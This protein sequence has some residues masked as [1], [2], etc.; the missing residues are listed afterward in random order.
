MTIKINVSFT[1]LLLTISSCNNILVKDRS[2]SSLES[3][4]PEI[5]FV[6]ASG[7]NGEVGIAML[8]NPTVFND[9]GLPVSDCVSSPVLPSGLSISS[10]TCSISGT[11]TSTLSTTTYTVTATN[12][13]GSSSTTVD[14]T[15]ASEPPVISYSSTSGNM[16]ALLSVTPALTSAG[17]SI[18]SCTSSP[19]L[20]NGLSIDNSTCVISGAPLTRLD[21]TSYTITAI[22]SGGGSTDTTFNLEVGCPIGYVPVDADSILGLPAFCVMKYEAKCGTSISG[23][24]SCPASTGAPDSTKF[25]VSTPHGVPWVSIRGQELLTACQNLNASFGVTEKFDTI[26]NLEWIA[27]ARSIEREASNWTSSKLNIGHTDNSPALACD[28]S[29]ENIETDCATTGADV[30][31]KRTYSLSNGSI[32]WDFAGNVWESVDW[33]QQSPNTTFDVGPQTCTIGWEEIQVKIDSCDPG[34]GTSGQASNLVSPDTPTLTSAT[35]N[36]GKIYG[37]A[38]G[39]A[40]RGGSWTDKAYYPGATGIYMLSLNMGLTA[41]GGNNGFRCVYRD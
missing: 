39:R 18:T 14:I 35:N 20:P 36:I 22:N 11:P 5:S 15:I 30:Y 10:S 37:G 3:L 33:V 32:V 1:L 31:Q 13:A 21:S 29:I 24:T 28:A 6:G 25:A 23:D 19:A 17:G 27:I 8:V 40:H 16:G 4:L 2:N 12:S 34:L 38:G 7:T 41:T 26:T 9:N